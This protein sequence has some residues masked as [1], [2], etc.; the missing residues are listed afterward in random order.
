MRYP[1]GRAE[2]R[3]IP[4]CTYTITDPAPTARLWIGVLPTGHLNCELQVTIRPPFGYTHTAQDPRDVD[5]DDI[6]LNT[7]EGILP[8]ITPVIDMATH[9]PD[10]RRYL[11]EKGYEI[12]DFDGASYGLKGEPDADGYSTPTAYAE[13]DSD[14]AFLT[15]SAMSYIS[16][17][18]G[19]LGG[20]LVVAFSSSTLGRDGSLQPDVQSQ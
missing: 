20:A 13:E 18:E 12:P 4:G 6:R 5:P 19:P 10:W 15:R 7:D 9:C 14:T 3:C 1:A 16:A 8:G 2:R 11:A 17:Q